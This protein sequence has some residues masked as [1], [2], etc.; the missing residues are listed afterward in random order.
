MTL[1]DIKLAIWDHK[2]INRNEVN[3]W[4][5]CD[6]VLVK[7]PITDIREAQKLLDHLNS[8]KKVKKKVETP[9]WCIDRY[10]K[11]HKDHFARQ[12]PHAYRD[13][14][15]L[16]M[17]PEW[18]DVGTSAGL[19]TLVLNYAAWMGCHGNR[20]NTVGRQLPGGKW[21]PGATKKGTSD[22]ALIIQGRSVHLEIKAGRDTPSPKQLEQQV[23]VRAAGGVYEFIYSAEGFFEV[24]DKCYILQPIQA[25]LL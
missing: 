13:G 4:T 3:L 9:R 16:G 6:K 11:A 12:Y 15:Y 10:E 24:F 23:K 25:T 17:E 7:I 22:T 21:I 18:P 5:E 20:I 2:K 1:Q 14:H 8:K 19:T